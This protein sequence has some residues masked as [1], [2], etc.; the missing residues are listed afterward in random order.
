MT[1]SSWLVTCCPYI[2]ILTVFAGLTRFIRLMPDSRKLERRNPVPKLEE[3]IQH[4]RHFIKTT[5]NLSN[6]TNKQ[7]SKGR[8]MY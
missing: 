3:K 5:Q 6:K 2:N 1:G 4:T 7:S 8:L